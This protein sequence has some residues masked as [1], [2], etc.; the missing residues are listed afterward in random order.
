MFCYFKT[1]RSLPSLGAW[2][3]CWTKDQQSVWCRIANLPEGYLHLP[4]LS[5]CPHYLWTDLGVCLLETTPAKGS[6][7]RLVLP[8][9]VTQ[10]SINQLKIS[11]K[12]YTKMWYVSIFLINS[13]FL[14]LYEMY[15]CRVNRLRKITFRWVL[16]Q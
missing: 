14:F 12:D 9:W 16:A 2:K 6:K 5:C 4:W 7:D 3:C 15:F 1:K 11:V 8:D 13:F 10:S